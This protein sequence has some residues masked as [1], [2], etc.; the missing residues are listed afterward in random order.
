MYG[1][2]RI[3]NGLAG[4][5][6]AS[7]AQQLMPRADEFLNDGGTDETCSSC[8]KYLHRFLPGIKMFR[9]RS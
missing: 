1:G 6:R 8:Y 4:G 2:S 3:G 7:E 9:L 5:V